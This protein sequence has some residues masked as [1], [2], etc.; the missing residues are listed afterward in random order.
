M[1]RFL[2]ITCFLTLG[3]FVQNTFAQSALEDL[4][5]LGSSD[6]GSS[7]GDS[8]ATI[9]SGTDVVVNTEPAKSMVASCSK[10]D[11]SF[12]PHGAFLNLLDSKKLNISHNPETGEIN[13]D[14][15]LMISNC[16][17]MLQARVNKKSGDLPYLFNVEIKK[18]AGCSDLCSYT[19]DVAD[20]ADAPGIKS[21]TKQVQV[22]PT[23]FGFMKCLRETGVITGGGEEG[24]IQV[25]RDKVVKAPFQHSQSGITETGELAFYS[26][27]PLAAQ[28]T[29]KFG[30]MGGIKGGSC[31]S[32]EK[33]AKNGFTIHSLED[34]TLARKQVLFDEIC[35][36]GDYKA[37]DKHLP[38]FE[39]FDSMYSILKNVRDSY[40][41]E[42]VKE[43][44][45]ELKANDYSNLDA[46]KFRSIL[47]DFQE[48]IIM[49]LQDDVAVLYDDL[50]R[51]N[52]RDERAGIQMEIDYKIK[53][54]IKYNRAP[55]VT[56][57]DRENMKSFAKKAPLQK[58]AWRE[59]AV[60][61][62]S[63]NITAFNFGKYASAD[64]LKEAG[65][66]DNTIEAIKSNPKSSIT[67][68][69]KE[70]SSTVS[71]E[72]EYVDQLGE[73]AADPKKSFAA[74]YASAATS[75]QQEQMQLDQALVQHLQQ[76]QM[77]MQQNCMNPQKYWM[78]GLI[79][80][81]CIKKYQESIQAT[82]M[83]RQQMPQMFQQQIAHYNHLA[84]QWQTVE[85]V[86]ATGKGVQPSAIDYQMQ[87]QQWVSP[88]WPQQQQ[89]PGQQFSFQPWQLQQGQGQQMPYQ[90]APYMN[91]Q[92]QQFNQFQMNQNRMPGNYQ[93]YPVLQQGYPQNGLPQ[94]PNYGPG[95]YPSMPAPG[96]YPQQ[97]Y[98]QQMPGY[99]QQPSFQYQFGY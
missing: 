74:E 15:G 41:L 53:K 40:L 47:E 32:F 14:G 35:A 58:E 20:E 2:E 73:L 99:Q 57:T 96:Q 72:K 94:T 5:A 69:E 46:E 80:Q 68:T 33:I 61:A 31:D 87:Q 45:A 24:P 29:P 26:K 60:T 16:N 63:N 28:M 75:L 34:V 65:L 12:M 17:S 71:I 85:Q 83:A 67:S 38:D 82:Q 95:V 62:Y 97:G 91:F 23:F 36:G 18:P 81:N 51:A 76:E 89:G 11:Q 78:T 52:S 9:T 79:Q 6:W 84:S 10:S 19:V 4:Q 37:I 48:K 42:E 66:P 55:Y 44:H 27:G 93:Q 70:I 86:R 64:A 43:L 21:G 30:K 54:L 3:L 90:Q 39:E 25:H 77:A 98:Q 92:S 13:I 1:K 59:A 50:K 49:P 22:E 7:G 88:G 56:D 8:G